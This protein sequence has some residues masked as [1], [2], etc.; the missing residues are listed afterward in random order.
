MDGY[1][2]AFL[3]VVLIIW[4]IK[5][6]FFKPLPPTPTGLNPDARIYSA[7]KSENPRR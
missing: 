1:L 3:A 5:R 6:I 4:V 7:P 2:A